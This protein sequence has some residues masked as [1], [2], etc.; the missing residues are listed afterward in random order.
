[1]EQHFGSLGKLGS[2]REGGAHQRL[3]FSC[4]CSTRK[5]H[6]NELRT[7]AENLGTKDIDNSVETISTLSSESCGYG[8]RK[9]RI[10]PRCGLLPPCYQ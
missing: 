9:C 5:Q 8:A 2:G 10:R 3:L 4:C 1:M 7:G 6:T